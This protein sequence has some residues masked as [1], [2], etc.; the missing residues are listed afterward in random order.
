MS[1]EFAFG[2]LMGALITF[3]VDSLFFIIYKKEIYERLYKE[4]TNKEDDEISNLKA[5]E[6]VFDKIKSEIQQLP[7]TKC[8]ETYRRYIVADDF[9]ENVLEIIDKYKVESEG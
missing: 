9:K 8:T 2:I 6:S 5:L 3:L 1:N 4:L 7:T